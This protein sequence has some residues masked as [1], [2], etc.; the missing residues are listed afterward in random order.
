[1]SAYIGD[2]VKNGLVLYLDAA[3]SKSY[4]SGSTSWVD[5][6]GFGNN[7]TLINGPTYT[8]TN[9]G[10]II[11]DGSNDYASLAT[12]A[13]F[14]LG[15]SPGTTSA[16]ILVS[17]GFDP[18]GSP[19]SI[20]TYGTGN[21]LQMRELGIRGTQ[22]AF[23]GYGNRVTSDITWVTNTWYNIVG[24]FSG[25]LVS[26]YVNGRLSGGPSTYAWN[27]VGSS[28]QVVQGTSWPVRISQVSVYNR[29]LSATEILENYNATK[30][31]FDTPRA[32][33]SVQPRL[34]TNGLVMCLDAGNRE[35]YVSGSSTIF[36]LSGTGNHGTLNNGPTFSSANNGSIVF[37]GS[38]DFI[39]TT[40]SVNNPQTYTVA[41]W[42]KTSTGG[43]KKI[44]GFESSQVG[45]GGN[46][47]R[48][49]YIG[50]DNKIYFGQ[51]DGANIRVATS[52]STY[53]DNIWHYIVG[54]F[55]SEGSTIRLY[56]DGVSVATGVAAFAQNYT[57]WWKI[58]GINLNLWTNGV[59]G[60]YTG[61]IA[62][63]HVYNRGLS[64]S[65]VLQNYNA[66]KGRFG[67]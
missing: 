59:N 7:A 4:V 14:P 57:G 8:T 46:Y 19:K 2:V 64:A 61:N 43:G 38:N 62:A 67:L 52:P 55:G 17:A 11:F 20:F 36:D 47:D 3:N 33:N 45:A 60:Y 23:D 48:N 13:S 39:S 31:R 50:T 30:G 5:L 49:L 65:E 58:G 22:F 1:M 18:G 37:D 54:T 44:I 35:S 27:T 24:T 32:I 51:V 6:S 10:F 34:V 42:F 53:N 12:S 9:K 15:T 16:W 40:N 28:S 63:A 21:T 41:A 29:A 56:V 25:S 66:L 26:L